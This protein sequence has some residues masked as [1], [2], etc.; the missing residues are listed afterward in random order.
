[1]SEEFFW[2]RKTLAEMD[3]AE[4]E[5]LCDG[6]GKCC[7]HKL[8][9]PEDGA[10]AYT[11]VVCW[12][13]DLESCRWTRYDARARLMPGCVTLDADNVSRLTWMP[14]T[15]AYR[16]IAEGKPLPPWH[17]LESG[18]RDTIHLAGKSVR[19]RVLLEGE[20]GDIQDHIVAWPE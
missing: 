3:A 16:L 13:L 17:H 7:L 20:T 8:E 19:G 1:M 5:A 9:H 4:W 2:R 12:L 10:I 18:D 6:C 15:C 11:E 14:S